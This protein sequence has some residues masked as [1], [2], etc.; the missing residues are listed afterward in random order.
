MVRQMTALDSHMRELRTFLGL[1]QKQMASLLSCS[2][3]SLLSLEL[4]RMRLS[5]K[6]ALK[7]VRATG[8]SL[9]WLLATGP[10]FVTHGVASTNPIVTRVTK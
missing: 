2:V 4:G 5:S 6:M 7:V 9:E 8:V 3:H 1:T 10:K